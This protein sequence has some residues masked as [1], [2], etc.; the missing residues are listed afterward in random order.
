MRTVRCPRCPVWKISLII[1]L[2]AICMNYTPSSQPTSVFASPAEH[3]QYDGVLIAADG[4]LQ[5][6]PQA[7]SPPEVEPN[8]QRYGF[9]LSPVETF[10]A[11]SYDVA[12]SYA[13]TL[14]A[15]SALRIDVRASADGQIWTTWETD[16]ANGATV[17]FP[18]A[19]R[20]AQFRATLFGSATAGPILHSARLS[21]IDG[22]PRYYA[23]EAEVAP[24]FRLRATRLGMVGGRTA[25][26]HIIR[27]RDQFVALPSWRALS[28]REGYEYQVRITYNGRS[29]VAP[30]W[31]VGPWNTRDDYW[32]PTRERYPELRR[33]WPQDHAAYFDGHNG[34]Y[35]EK[36]YVRFP[37]GIDVADGVWWD[38]LGIA[39]DQ[40][41]VEVTFLWLG[42]DPQ[43]APPP[44]AAT[45]V[46]VDDEGPAF[47]PSAAIWYHGPIECGAGGHTFS[48]LTTTDP[49]ASKN[50]ARW[51]PTLTAEALYDVYVHVP[52]CAAPD[53]VTTQA[54]YLV[55]HRDGTQEVV[56]N[57]ARQTGWVLLGQFPFAVG[58]AGSVQLTDVA[59]AAM[60]TIWFDDARWTPVNQ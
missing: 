43:A 35:A 45:E 22:P 23:L 57:Q 28:S 52:V 29:A 41:E 12:V 6:D 21:A 31:D 1:F 30:V 9:Y 51:Q 27:P 58:D 10:S 54:R 7:G 59:G 50:T 24:T 56:V 37:T 25:N 13:A 42:R 17:H 8:Y 15:G 55:Q 39:G 16:L 32:S 5:L 53:P 44:P 60:H 46:V 11:P 38:K 20:M 2:A 47:H 3:Y 26:G 49:K 36:G 14:P 40:A 18:R 33:G 4:T 34:G 19:M 48:A